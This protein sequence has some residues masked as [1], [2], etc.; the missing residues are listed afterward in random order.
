MRLKILF[1]S[2]LMIMGAGSLWAQSKQDMKGTFEA[3][4][5]EEFFYT[6]IMDPVGNSIESEG[7]VSYDPATGKFK[8]SKDC[9]PIKCV[10]I[11]ECS[12]QDYNEI[13]NILIFDEE[14]GEMPPS[15]VMVEQY[16]TSTD[17]EELHPFGI[18]YDN[19]NKTFQ[20]TY[21]LDVDDPMFEGLVFKR[22]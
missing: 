14:D 4:Y 16:C 5:Q 15:I 11:L 10:G 22:M 9:R 18:T 17:P 1:C 6:L 7:Y 3:D 21:M 2:C 12:A 20:L 8:V 19:K 13:F